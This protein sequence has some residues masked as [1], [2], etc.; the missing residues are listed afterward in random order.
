[1]DLVPQF[2]AAHGLFGNNKTQSW[3][4]YENLRISKKNK[5]SLDS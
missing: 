3:L 4:P 1:M 5:N 2:Y